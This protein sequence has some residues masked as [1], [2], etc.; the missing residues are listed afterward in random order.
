MP[1][2]G[3]E[4]EQP[5]QVAFVPNDEVYLGYFDTTIIDRMQGMKIIQL[6]GIHD[7]ERQEIKLIERDDF[8]SSWAAGVREARNGQDLHYADYANNQYAFSAGYEHWHNRK[9]RALKGKLVH[10]SSDIEY[11]CHGFIDA[12]ND[13]P[14]TQN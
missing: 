1:L 13:T 10:Y 14:Y 12:S 3:T 4:Y 6:I 5:P 11:I 8:L 2:D 7:D 9:K